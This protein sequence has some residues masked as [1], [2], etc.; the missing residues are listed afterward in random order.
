MEENIRQLLPSFFGFAFYGR[1]SGD[2]GYVC[3]FVILP[4]N[5]A[6]GY[7]KVFLVVPLM[8]DVTS[9]DACE[10]DKFLEFAHSVYNRRISIV[11]ALVSVNSNVNRAFAGKLK[12]SLIGCYSHLYT[13]M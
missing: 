6:L 1:A 10:H 2:T 13:W 3:I 9:L 11:G 4:D 5:C 7:H 8:E 12:S